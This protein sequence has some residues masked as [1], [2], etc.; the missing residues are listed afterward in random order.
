MNRALSAYLAELEARGFSLSS[1]ESSSYALEWLII[2]LRE[3][4]HVAD[5]RAVTEAQLDGFL[6]HLREHRTRKSQPLKAATI[7]RLR[8]V[9]RSFFAWQ[10][11][12]GR[13]I[14][15][16]AERQTPSKSEYPLPHVLNESDITRLIE[17]PDCETAIGLRDRALMELLY[18]TGIRHAEAHR[19]DLYDVDTSA[20]RLTIRAGKGKRDRI[21]PVTENAAHWLTKYLSQARSEL[22]GGQRRKGKQREVPQLASPALWLARTGKRLSYSWIEQ[23]IKGYAIEAEVKA[24]VHTFRHC[25]ASHL[26]RHGASVRHIQKL[27]GHSNLRATEIYL[28]LDTADLARAVARLPQPSLKA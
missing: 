25:C 1:R 8:S 19:L 12:R 15:N 10:T 7:N 21:V 11:R 20:R 18:A 2:F 5:W 17:M 4:H 28:H 26:L 6:L 13:L 3:R 16:P 27:L 22:A 9:V 24:N 23:I 14:Y